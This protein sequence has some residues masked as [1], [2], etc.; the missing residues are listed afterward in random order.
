MHLVGA[1]PGGGTDGIVV[2]KFHVRRMSIPV[3]FLFIDDHSE[4]LSHDMVHALEVAV[5]VRMIGACRCFPLALEFVD[6]VR[7]LGAELEAVVGVEANGTP[8]KRDVLVHQD[9]SSAFGC[10]SAAE[11][12]Y[13][14]AR[15]LKRPVK[16]RM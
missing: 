5:A 6:S 1:Q 4:H 7:Q 10:N 8:P 14:S 15:R 13:I 11:T 3:I 16:R 2:S 12:A 9:V